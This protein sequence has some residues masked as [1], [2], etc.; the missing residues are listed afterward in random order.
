VIF[1]G[2]TPELLRQAPCPVLVLREPEE[3]ASKSALARPVRRLMVPVD[4]SARAELAIHRA[5]ALATQCKAT[6]SLLHIV[7]PTAVDEDAAMVGGDFAAYSADASSRLGSL[8]DRT[9][10]AQLRGEV[11]IRRGVAFAQIVAEAALREMDLLVLTTH[12]RTGLAHFLMGSTAERVVSHAPCPVVV[13]R[14]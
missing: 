14:Q 5:T 12:G 9:V 1:G 10:P 4:F 2:I 3:A 8:L 13:V 6:V 7:D 11:F